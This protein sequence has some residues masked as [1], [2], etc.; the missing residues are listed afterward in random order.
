ML[1]PAEENSGVEHWLYIFCSCAED[2]FKQQVLFTSVTA[3]AD[4]VLIYIMNYNSS[5]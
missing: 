4:L 1:R 3:K 2:I 5:F